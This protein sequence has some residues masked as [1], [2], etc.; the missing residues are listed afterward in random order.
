MIVSIGELQK[1]IS[2]IKNTKEPIIVIDKRT[3]KRIA[4]IEPI[5]EENDLELFNKLL[6]F[7][8]KVDKAYSKK[9]FENIYTDYLKKKYDIS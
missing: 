2:L 9:D 1:N 3:K 7:E 6:S 4:K 8:K 5:K